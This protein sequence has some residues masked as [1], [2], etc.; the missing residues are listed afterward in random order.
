MDKLA[1]FFSILG[2]PLLV[3]P[4]YV[5]A[6]AY[7]KLSANQ[8]LLLSGLVLGVVT[9][10]IIIHNSYKVKT[11]KYSN[12][13]VS[14]R[15]QRKGFYPFLLALFLCIQALNYWTGLPQEVMTQTWI[16]IGML[17]VSYLINFVLKASLHTSILF[18]IS[19]SLLHV[20]F[21][22]I[23]VLMTLAILT[24]WSRVYTHKHQL[25]EVLVG[26]LVGAVFG[27]IAM[28]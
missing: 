13:D 24:A 15:E 22:W 12:F 2:H 10:P 18:F 1:R 23:A 26:G 6:M 5:T 16:F 7:D 19:F 20:G 9:I 25:S 21:P 8:A 3:G 27:W 17:L 14:Q 11:G 4:T 28:N